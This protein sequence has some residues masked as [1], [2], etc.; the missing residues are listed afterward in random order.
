[1]WV[2]CEISTVAVVVLIETPWRRY[3]RRECSAL[4]C[5]DPFSYR[6][7]TYSFW[8]SSGVTTQWTSTGNTARARVGIRFSKV[9]LY[10]IVEIL[11]PDKGFVFPFPSRS[12]GIVLQARMKLASPGTSTCTSTPPRTRSRSGRWLWCAQ[13]CFTSAQ[14]TSYDCVWTVSYATTWCWCSYCPCSRTI[15]R[16]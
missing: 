11:A 12:S 1:M 9:I 13:S 7:F 8:R 16:G 14:R 2:L 3:R 5:W 4:R 6:P 10:F 15:T